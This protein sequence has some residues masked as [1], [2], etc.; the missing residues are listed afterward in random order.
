MAN[1]KDPKQ[2]EAKKAV[3]EYKE[4]EKQQKQFLDDFAVMEDY[5]DAL[6]KSLKGEK[7]EEK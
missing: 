5:L 1:K 4:W 3:R 6:S 7:T 2:Q